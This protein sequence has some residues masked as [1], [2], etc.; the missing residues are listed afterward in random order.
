M[1]VTGKTATDEKLN[2]LRNWFDA[3]DYHAKISRLNRLEWFLERSVT[4]PI[5]GKKTGVD[6]LLGLIPG[7]GD[8]IA[9]ALG[10]YIIAEALHARAPKAMIIR[11]VWNLGFDTLVGSVPIAGDLFDFFYS[12]N[13]KN[14]K[15][16]KSHLES[17]A[18]RNVIIDMTPMVVK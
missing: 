18:P 7:G 16:L 15:L 9:G 1:V 5:L 17:I 8:I 14:L 13:G 2:K 11:M 3:P 6:A 4:I 10:S 12:S